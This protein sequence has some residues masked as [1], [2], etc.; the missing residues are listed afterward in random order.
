MTRR[1]VGIRNDKGDKYSPV[2]SQFCRYD[3]AAWY[4]DFLSLISIDDRDKIMCKDVGSVA[5]E[6]YLV[7]D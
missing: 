5:V 1:K 4:S 7:F 6:M 3:V 2:G